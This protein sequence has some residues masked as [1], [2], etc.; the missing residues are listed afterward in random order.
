MKRILLSTVL[1]FGLVG[2]SQETVKATY[3]S[4]QRV[5]FAFSDFISVK[6][7]QKK[8]TYIMI[9]KTLMLR[10]FQG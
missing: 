4:S 10:D 6:R 8:Y 1:L 5:R 9:I 7:S 3:V 2:F